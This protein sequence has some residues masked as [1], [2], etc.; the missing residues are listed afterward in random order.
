[1]Q[2]AQVEGELVQA[3]AEA[4]QSVG[5]EPI[6]LARV[7]L[8]RHGK[9]VEAK[10]LH[11]ALF[12]AARAPAGAF[13]QLRV[14]GAGADGAFQP[15]AADAIAH[16]ADLLEVGQQI[17]TVLCQPVADGR[18]FGGLDVGEGNGGRMRLRRDACGEDG[19]Q[20]LQLT[21]DEIQGLAQ[22]QR[23]D[24]V[25]HIH[26]GGAEV[27][28][29]A[30]HSALAGKGLD[31]RHEVVANLALD[32]LGGGD[33]DLI[34]VGAQIGHLRGGDQAGLMLGLGQRDPEAAQQAALARLAPHATHGVATVAPGER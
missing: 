14:G 22:T 18:R 29:G 27:D 33:V 3:G 11:D 25:K 9:G 24:V 6:L 30:A 13:Q 21:G 12:E 32:G 34:L 7:G 8:R 17:Q 23:I 15:L 20:L 2:D 19:E 31:L 1:M 26:G 4:G 16:A 10:L 28:D 5:D